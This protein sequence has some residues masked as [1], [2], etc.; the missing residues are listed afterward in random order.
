VNFLTLCRRVFSEAG[1]S[2]QLSSCENQ[3]GEALRVVQWVAQGYSDILNDQAMAWKFIH[4][5]Y[6]KQLTPDKGT[7]S[8][9]EIGVPNGVQW[10]TRSMRVAINEDLSDE[11]FLQHMRFPE[12]RDYWLFSSRRTVASRPLNAACD[13]EMNLRLAP[14]PADA[15]WLNFQA[16]AQAPDL[17]RNEDTPVFPERFHIGIVWHALRSYG[18]FEAAPEVVSR[19]DSNLAKTLFLLELDQSDEVIVGSPIC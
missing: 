1:I 7:Y 17:V 3:T 8:F 11:T 16:Q 5:T 2:G 12:F 10:D 15:Y 6:T 18:M 4:K 19:A 9:E 13:N 14:I